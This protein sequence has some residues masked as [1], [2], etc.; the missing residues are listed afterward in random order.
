MTLI[1]KLGQVLYFYQTSVGHCSEH[2]SFKSFCSSPMLASVLCFI[3]LEQD[4]KSLRPPK[5]LFCSSVKM[6]LTC[7]LRMDEEK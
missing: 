7:D 2:E 1:S 4:T 3:A 6:T 5:L